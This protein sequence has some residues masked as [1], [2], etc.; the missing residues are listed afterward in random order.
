M[1][2][3]WCG[4]CSLHLCVI[5]AVGCVL[6]R[7]AQAERA[8]SLAAAGLWPGPCAGLFPNSASRKP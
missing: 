3:M 2:P 7:L 5:P 1:G 8:L 6:L 4:R